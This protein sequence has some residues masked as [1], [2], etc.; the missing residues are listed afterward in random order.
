[1]VKGHPAEIIAGARS[2]GAGPWRYAARVLP[3]RAAAF[4]RFQARVRADVCA[5]AGVARPARP[6]AR[7]LALAALVVLGLGGIPGATSR[8]LS[9]ELA[10]PVGPAPPDGVGG[11]ERDGAIDVTVRGAPDSTSIARPLPGAHVRALSIVDDRAYLADARDTDAQGHARLAKLPRGDTWLLADAPG[12]ARGSTHLT[13]DAAPRSVTLDLAPERAFDVAVNDDLGAPVAGAAIEV[14]APV[15]PLPVGARAGDDG[16]AHV[17]RL[18]AG[19]WHATVRAPGYEDE[20]RLV[21]D[22][23]TLAVVLRKLGAITAHVVGEGAGPAGG[24]RVAIAGATLWP[25]RVA[26]ADAQGDVRIGSLAAGTYALRATREGAV[27]PTEIDVTLER[28]QEKDVELRLAAGRFVSVR[29]TDGDA[30]DADAIASARVTLAEGGLSPFPLEGTTDRS[31][32]I[33]LGPVAPGGAALGVRADGFVA[34]GAIAVADPPPAE[35]RVALVRA[36]SIAGRVLDARG[37][38]VDG[39][40]IAIVGTDPTGQPIFDDPRRARFQAAHFDAML[41]G[42]APLLPGG[43]LG[44]VPGPV[45]AIPRAPGASI[46]SSLAAAIAGG[47]G[48]GD[49]WVTRADGTFLVSPASPGRVRA[50]V[51]HPEYV[52][53][54]SDLVTLAP[55]GSAQVD[56]V[57]RQGGAL[58]GRVLDAHDRP[59]EGARML[60][61]AA[62]GSFERSTLSASDGTFAFVALP[63]AILLTATA[64]SADAPDARLAVSIPDGGRKEVTI[65][66]PEPREPLPVT[67]VDERGYPVDAAQVTASALSPDAWLRTTS[68]TDKHGEARLARARGL[69]LR[70]EVRAPSRAPRAVT[71]DGTEDALRIELTPAERATGEVVTERGRDPI[72]GATVTLYTDLGPRRAVTD[73]RGGFEL[74]ELAAGGARLG[75]R[76]PGFAPIVRMLTIP[77][78]AGNR[79]FAIPRIEL[80]AEGSVEGDVVDARGDPVAGA[81]VARDSVPTWVLVGSNP[82]AIAVTDSAGR[83]ALHQLP[84]GTTAIEAYA[85]GLGRARATGVNVVAGR[86]TDRLHLVVGADDPTAAP[87]PAASGGVAVTLGETAAPTEVVVVS[88]VEQS[89]AERAGIA[90]GDVVVSVDGAGVDGMGEA[91]AKLSGPIGQDVVV[92]IRRGEHSLA[93]RVAREAVRR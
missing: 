61:T 40:T 55:G 60:A 28:G 52:E 69:A 18:G 75:V 43:E 76:A 12:R 91:R 9:D 63:E 21:S 4:A 48:S 17:G 56:V 93:L 20:T 38:P 78:S 14:V 51:R 16:R 19:P 11:H 24:A 80:A 8:P 2:T 58:E 71:A 84:E 68:F 85:P 90:P 92:G 27:S 6:A 65:T 25:A 42:P 50:I 62:D 39:A 31:G 89:E 3:G 5:L 26:V 22:G 82:D 37:R 32:R 30:Q 70:V 88:V 15:D 77:D 46:A 57:L 59:V 47:P 49:P 72:P 1:M 87:E 13:V 33:R 54:Q 64:G 67:V 41:A 35:T 53:A 36:G 23:E 83:F 74:P 10:G 73:A 79:A 29:V 86:T 7:A 81:R 34:R 66:L 44:V 45:P